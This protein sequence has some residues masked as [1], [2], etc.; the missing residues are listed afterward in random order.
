MPAFSNKGQQ[1]G[2]VRPGKEYVVYFPYEE[3]KVKDIVRITS[4]CDCSLTYHEK[5]KFRIKVVYT[6]K[7][8]PPTHQSITVEKYVEVVYTTPIGTE[9]TEKLSFFATVVNKS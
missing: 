6:P 7:P 2:V 8:L 1:L 4:P 3:I 9:Q 5:K